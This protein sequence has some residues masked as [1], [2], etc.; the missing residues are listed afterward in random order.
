M[1]K[2]KPGK[3]RS[4]G[5][6]FSRL[7]GR[8]K[9]KS[10]AGPSPWAVRLRVALAI[11][12]WACLAAAVSVGFL[13]LHQYIRTAGPAADKVGP[14]EL[15]GVPDWLEPAWIE[16]ITKTAGAASFPLNDQS[17]RHIAEQLKT[18]SWMDQVRVQTTPSRLRIEALY[19]K[20]VARLNLPAGRSAY[21]DEQGTIL[22]PLPLESMPLVEIRG[23][24]AE[25]VPPPGQICRAK[26]VD[27]AVKLLQILQRMDQKCC[28]EKPLLNEIAYIDISNLLR[29]KSTA[30]PH[31][32]LVARDGTPI[33]WGAAYGRAALC[34]EADETEK[35][36][37]LYNFYTRSGYTLQGKVRYIELRT[38]AEDRPRPR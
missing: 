34:F 24:P 35:L 19:R 12:A 4:H 6:F 38:P 7:T 22:D 8:K 37:A 18:L 11:L 13:Y 17:A 25:T 9:T 28:P 15:V 23:L 29:Q 10:P 2:R 1:K 14:I 21:I 32:I 5:G 3:P 30:K 20:P 16:T 26:E 36:T 31:I 33:H 27:E